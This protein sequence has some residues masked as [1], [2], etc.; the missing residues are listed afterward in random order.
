MQNTQVNEKRNI[1]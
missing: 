1:K